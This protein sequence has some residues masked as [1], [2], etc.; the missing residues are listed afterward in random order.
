MTDE[1][2]RR[3]HD[4]LPPDWDNGPISLVHEMCQLLK[5]IADQGTSMD[6]GTMDGEADMII[7]VGGVEYFIIVRRSNAQLAKDGKWFPTGPQS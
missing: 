7:S 4:I 1:T 5:P 6:T 3:L 2:K